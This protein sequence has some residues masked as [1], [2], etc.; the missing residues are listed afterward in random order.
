M[1]HTYQSNTG[2]WHKRLY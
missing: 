2:Q 1:V